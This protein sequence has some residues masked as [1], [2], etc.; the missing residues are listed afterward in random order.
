[1]T[2]AFLY[3]FTLAV[4][5]L[6]ACLAHSEPSAAE[7]NLLLYTRGVFAE[8]EGDTTSAREHYEATLAGDVERLKTQ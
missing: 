7:K 8:L 1:M 2:A 4:I 5:S 3:R 6:S